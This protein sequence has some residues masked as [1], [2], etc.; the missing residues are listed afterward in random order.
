MTQTFSGGID[1]L[2]A[3]MSGPVFGPDDP[4]YDEARRV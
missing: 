2:R 3:A 1:M 4:D